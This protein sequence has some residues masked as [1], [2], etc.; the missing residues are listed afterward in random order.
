MDVGLDSPPRES[1]AGWVLAIDFGTS[2]TGAAIRFDD[3]R[4]D[5]V[6]LSSGSD[7]MPSA[8]VRTDGPANAPGEKQWRVGQ[9][10]LN[11]RRT[12][13]STFVGAPKTRLGQEAAVFGDDLVAPAQIVAPVL[14]TVRERAVRAAGG[15]EP[16][17]VLLTH[18]V[19][20]GRA[21][22]DALCQAAVAAGFAAER[23]WLLP[24]PVA[25]FHAHTTTAQLDPGARVAI[26]DI[27]G[28]TC[29]VA[30]LEI[31]SGGGL[32]VVAQ[33]GDDRLGGNDLDDLLYRWVTDQ[34]SLSGHE[35]IVDALDDP[36][37][38]G[39]VL[40]LIDTV[41]AA[42]QDLSE[43]PSAPVAVQVGGMEAV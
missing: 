14:R 22:T 42:K 6:T 20:W 15:T 23:L 2:N 38:L 37:N 8:V 9:A 40:T 30:V 24:E 32:A 33:A 26:V 18:P 41:R 28:G 3:G 43:Y 10:A 35:Q 17:Q 11:A 21:R 1:A 4:I 5:K 16:A 39:A 31:T 36:E 34:L 25:A 19:G 27:G 7:T 13:P 29:D 12:N